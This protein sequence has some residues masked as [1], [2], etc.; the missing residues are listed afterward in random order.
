MCGPNT[1]LVAVITGAALAGSPVAMRR[2]TERFG[3]RKGSG[4]R[5]EKK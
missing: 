2:V 3:S 5:S 1:V 4:S